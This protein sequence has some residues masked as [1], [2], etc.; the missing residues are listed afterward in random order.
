MHTTKSLVLLAS[1]AAA[2]AAQAGI[3]V[4]DNYTADTA[5]IGVQWSPETVVAETFAQ[6]NGVWKWDVTFSKTSTTLTALFHGLRLADPGTAFTTWLNIPVLGVGFDLGG[7][8]TPDASGPAYDVW[9]ASI[10]RNSSQLPLTFAVSAVH[11]TGTNVPEPQEYAAIAGLG[12]IGFA[13][14]RRSKA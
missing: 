9:T 4:T 11:N 1:F 13:A 14:Y 5:S 3:T 8:I 12:L 7:A 10:F 6:N 2:T